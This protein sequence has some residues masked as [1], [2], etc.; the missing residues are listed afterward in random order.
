MVAAVVVLFAFF[1]ASARSERIFSARAGP[2]TFPQNV[3]DSKF[4]VAYRPPPEDG[5]IPVAEPGKESVV[6]TDS[7][8]QKFLCILPHVADGAAEGGRNTST[9]EG[10]GTA[11]GGGGAMAE[12]PVRKT[13]EELL[14]ALR[15]LPCFYRMEGWWTYELC[16]KKWMRQ[17]HTENDKIVA[18]FYLG[19][20]DA[21]KTADLHSGSQNADSSDTFMQKDPRSLS[22]A[23]RYHA[24]VY[25]DGTPCDLT[26]EKRQTEVRYVCSE[27][28][29]NYIA[30]IKEAP[31]CHY[32]VI[33]H[34]TVL[35]SHPLFKKQ[36][37]P[38]HYINCHA[39]PPSSGTLAAM[40]DTSQTPS[41]PSAPPPTPSPA[42]LSDADDP[43]QAIGANWDAK[44]FLKGEKSSRGA[45]S[46][47]QKRGNDVQD[48]GEMEGSDEE[49][50]EAGE[51]LVEID[52]E[53]EELEHEL[54]EL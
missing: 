21:E 46:E 3:H 10:S 41:H 17:Y 53:E 8:G 7:E 30:S 11:A 25:T 13:P 16:F 48:E 37:E 45:S 1:A 40:A 4:L 15:E 33:I 54:T 34:T 31:T 19:R 24:H 9:A 44:D 38:M 12:P 43:A 5:S 28:G 6:M 51:E 26:N 20:W 42:P 50:E 35:C 39:F 2:I 23:Q 49:D 47:E 22:A 18:E 14:G 27:D 52:P 29:N 32:Q 36:T